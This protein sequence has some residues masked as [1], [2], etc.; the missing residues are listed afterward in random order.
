MLGDC[1]VFYFLL[2][3]DKGVV[4][5]GYIFKSVDDVMVRGCFIV[6]N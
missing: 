1:D 5:L 4:L 3:L 6:Y 2:V